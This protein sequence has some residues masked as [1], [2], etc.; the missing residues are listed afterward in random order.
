MRQ[1]KTTARPSVLVTLFLGILLAIPS[2]ARRLSAA[3][4]PVP[5]SP[6]W[7]TYS[8][9]K[10]PGAGKHVV[11]I[12]ADQEYRSEYSMPMLARLLAKHH[13]FHCTVLYSLNTDNDVDPK[14]KIR[15]A[16][17][18]VPPNIRRLEQQGK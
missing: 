9:D 13:G 15:L 18:R 14:R 1:T 10:V 11:L 6:L 16:D 12:A 4:H 2:N 17:T 7:L 3:D 5:E 8:G